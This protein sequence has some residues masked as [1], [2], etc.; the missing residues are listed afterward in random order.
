MLL[1][2]HERIKLDMVAGKAFQTNYAEEAVSARPKYEV[3]T[4]VC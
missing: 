2:E 4:A 1:G 3:C